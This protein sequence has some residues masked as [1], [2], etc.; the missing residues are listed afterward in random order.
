MCLIAFNWQ[1][2]APVP[3]IIAAN[4]DEFYARPTQALHHWADQP[5]VAGKDLQANGTW[6]GV[7][8]SGRVAAL[9]NYRDA[10]QFRP[11]AP[12]RGDLT[13]AFLDAHE[14]CAQYL[15]ALAARAHLYNPFNLLVFDGL[16]LMGFESR[17]RRAFE[18]PQGVGVVSNADFNV[19]WPKVARL[20]DGFTQT[21]RQ[22]IFDAESAACQ[23]GINALLTLLS[24]RRT[25]P[26]AH[27]PQTGIPLEREKALSA[28]FIHTPDYGTRASS[29]V[30]VGRSHADFMERSFNVD[31][32]AGEVQQRIDWERAS[33]FKQPVNS[34]QTADFP[35]ALMNAGM[36]RSSSGT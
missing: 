25:A 11:G 13:T 33:T 15:E 34:P 14:T 27:L 1:P 32:F 24:D 23:P 18:L 16:S 28:A 20:R 2:Q 10:A 6:L 26:D 17:H 30:L 3:L 7:S 4:R 29:V 21:L 22:N 35:G 8:L 5:I 19:P 36:K 9:T 31:G 12:S